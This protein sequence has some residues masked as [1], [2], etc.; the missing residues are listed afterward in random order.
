MAE[1]D[2]KVLSLKEALERPVAPEAASSAPSGSPVRY[3]LRIDGDIP[4][5]VDVARLLT[6]YGVS[7]KRAHGVLQGIARGEA[8]VV[9]LVVEAPDAPVRPFAVFGVEALPLRIP[10]ISTRAIRGRLKLSQSEFALRFGFELD[11][12]QNWDQ[13]RN[14]PDAATKVLLAIIDRDPAI[15]DAVLAGETS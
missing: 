5:P 8:V 15:V 9:Q 4:R 7:L 14:Q 6:E 2:A 3:R 13:G 10:E 12:V 1:A 11:T